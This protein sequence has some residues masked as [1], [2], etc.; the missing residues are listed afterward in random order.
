[1]NG[2]VATVADDAKVDAKMRIGSTM[3]E[4]L[5]G[6]APGM[7]AETGADEEEVDEEDPDDGS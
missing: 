6:V 4:Y 3:G 7:E 5:V 1:M 2:A